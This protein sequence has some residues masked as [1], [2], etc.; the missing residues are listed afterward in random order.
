MEREEHAGLRAVFRHILLPTPGR[1]FCP[2]EEDGVAEVKD[3]LIALL[4][5]ESDK[6]NNGAIIDG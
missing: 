1:R 3:E 6:A 2:D 5:L 4:M